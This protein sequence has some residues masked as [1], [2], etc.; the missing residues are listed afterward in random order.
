MELLTFLAN[1]PNIN[2]KVDVAQNAV[3]KLRSL[4]LIIM[5]GTLLEIPLT[6]DRIILRR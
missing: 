3:N 5:S 6:L 2:T 4:S 1:E